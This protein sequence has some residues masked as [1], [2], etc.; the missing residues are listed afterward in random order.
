MKNKLNE[1]LD[2]EINRFNSIVKYQKNL[3]EESSYYFHQQLPEDDNQEETN[4]EQ[5][6]GDNNQMGNNQQQTDPGAVQPNQGDPNQNEPNFDNN[7]PNQSTD[8]GVEEPM[9][10]N[11]DMDN[12]DIDMT[13]NEDGLGDDDT[14]EVDVTELVNNSNELK[15]KISDVIGK[16]DQN[17]QK[18]ADI[19]KSVDFIQNSVGKMDLLI[20]KME[21]LTK[22]VELSRPATEEERRKALAKDSY[23]FSVTMDEYEKGTGTKNQTQM[24][25]NPKM[26]MMKAIMAD[27]NDTTVKDSFYVPQNNPYKNN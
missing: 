22:Q 1:A 8:T 21:E 2:K 3:M 16:I 25:K 7:D 17:N 19:I 23:P 27:Y 9:G 6:M 20:G 18:F 10:T 13:G 4:M 5:P 12:T 14:T 15:L 26:S 24:E 11:T